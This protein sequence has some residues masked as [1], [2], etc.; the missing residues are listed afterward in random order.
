[1]KAIN[2]KQAPSILI[3]KLS[4]VGDIVH[5]TAVTHHLKTQLAARITWIVDSGLADLLREH[6][7]VDELLLFPRDPFRP[8]HHSVVGFVP[9]MFRLVNDLRKQSYDLAIDLQ[10]RGRSYLL[11]QFAK[12]RVKVGRG[13][14][15]FLRKK[16][17]HR[18]EDSRHAVEAGFESTDMLGIPR[19][20]QLHPF[21]P[22]HPQD[23][24]WVAESLKR[25]GVGF[26]VACFLPF[27]SWP[28]K[29]WDLDRWAEVADW[30][31]KKGWSVL[32]T[33][34]AT[35]RDL[36]ESIVAKTE[37]PAQI[38]PVF[39]KFS[40]RELISLFSLVQ[41]VVGVDTGPLHIAVAGGCSVLGLY[42]PTDPER[43]GPWQGA[44]KTG[45]VVTAAGC[46][47]CR[48]PRCRHSCMRNL[49]VGQVIDKISEITERTMFDER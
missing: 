5:S 46:D 19:P 27:S 1:M 8:L 45:S 14:F 11:L 7:D 44:V 30:L 18:R 26:P 17:L 22:Y 9:Q 42:G 21:L 37:R 41:L 29:G 12:A 38:L 36:G 16:V 39:G 33:G 28:S 31:A 40:L 32:L 13:R 20:D 25:L 34:S 10:G 47:V 2:T 43:T 15:P 23:K 48:R 3:I 49:H 24:R 35:Q 6:P 4:S